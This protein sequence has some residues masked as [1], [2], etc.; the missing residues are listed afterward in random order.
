MNYDI[1]TFGSAT[2]DTFLRL[3]K[4]NYRILEERE[5]GEEKS[6]CFPLGAKIFIEDLEVASGG[7]AT[8]TACTFTNQG[9]KVAVCTKVGD[10]KRG[11]AIIEE[12]KKFK[13]E[14]KFIKKD[15]KYR[16][17]FSAILSLKG[18]RTILI[19]RGACHFMKPDDIPWEKL[20]KVKWFYLAPLSEE[21]AQLFKPL[22]EFAK[23]NKIKVAANP[24]N[25]QLNLGEEVLKPILSQINIL[26]LNKEEASLLAKL[27]PENEKALLK[28]LTSFVK[29]IV[30]ITKGKEG[31]V[32]SDG[33][34]VYRAPVPAVLPFEKTGA[35]DAFGA[36]FLGGLLQKND[37]EYAIQLATANATS[38]I[39]KI[40]AKNGLLKKGEWG[41]WPR[42]KVEKRII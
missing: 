16:T 29:G 1:I 27:S 5:F 9:F 26:I 14:T 32:V 25:T 11:E 6:L 36:G 30:V 37:I 10:D 15:K 39:Q 4:D 3:K 19:Y 21:S 33:K 41:S 40:G 23:E 12:L 2:R 28:K 35:G 31:S 24:G 17:A 7:G 8:N 13:V 22:V 18:E 38:C 20:K 34:Y 42:V